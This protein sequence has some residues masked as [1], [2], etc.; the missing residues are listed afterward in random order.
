MREMAMTGLA[1]GNLLAWQSQD[2][3]KLFRIWWIKLN[4]F[5]SI[6]WHRKDVGCNTAQWRNKWTCCSILVA[7][8]NHINGVV[9]N[10]PSSIGHVLQLLRDIVSIP[11]PGFGST[12]SLSA[13]SNLNELIIKTN[14][15]YVLVYERPLSWARQSVT[16]T[17]KSYVVLNSS[18]STARQSSL[19]YFRELHYYTLYGG[20]GQG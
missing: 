19:G 3:L 18:T 16:L 7:V 1:F 12:T 6:I 10:N 20:V 17:I 13:S 5:F 14:G 9:W 2:K 11:Q 8:F 15:M 4:V